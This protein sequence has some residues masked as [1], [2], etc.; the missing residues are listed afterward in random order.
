MGIN[1]SV[2]GRNYFS[3]SSA[4]EQEDDEDAEECAASLADAIALKKLAVDYAHPEDPVLISDSSVFG[5]NYFSRSS[6]PEQED[7]EDAEE[8]AVAL[9]DAISLKKLAV[10]YA[11]PEMPVKIDPSVFGR[12]YF[13]R[14]SASQHLEKQ[15]ADELIENLED[16]AALKKLAVDYAHPEEPVKSSDPAAFGRNYFCRPLAPC[17][18]ELVSST[19]VSAQKP[20]FLPKEGNVQK[21][22]FD[23]DGNHGDLHAL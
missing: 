9:A 16:M 6:A 7:D 8:C 17:F 3:R 13:C 19:G 12:N 23:F 15:K 10:D 22:P 21:D 20:L 2:F 1:P 14:P 18:S 5:R 11:H 4:P